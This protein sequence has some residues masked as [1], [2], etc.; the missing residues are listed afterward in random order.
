MR[1]ATDRQQAHADHQGEHSVYTPEMVVDGTRSFVGSRR[2]K[3][4]AAI[5]QA[6]ATAV[7]AAPLRISRRGGKLAIEVGQGSG[8]GTVLLVGFDPEHSTTVGEGENGG[9]RLLESNIV[10]SVQVVGRW[11]GASLRLQQPVPAGE[12]FAAILE[13]PDGQII[14]AARLGGAIS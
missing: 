13:T 1:A 5:R 9:R 3:A 2:G 7:T 11:T 8:Q 4:D 14:G 6:E 10:R 12:Q